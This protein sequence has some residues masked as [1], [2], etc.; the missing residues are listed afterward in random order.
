MRQGAGVVG[1]IEKHRQDI[2]SIHEALVL[3]LRDYAAKCRFKSVVLGLSGGIDSAVVCTLAVAALGADCV[4]GV[5]MP[6]RYSS[7]HSVADAKELAHN[8]GIHFHVI[9][10]ESA[11]IAFENMLSGVFAGLR[12]DLA[13]ENIQAR[14]RGTTLMALSNKFNHLLLT[15]GNKSEVATGYCTL[16]GDMAG[17]LAVISDVPKMV[18]YQLAE[19]I[20]QRAGR[21]LIP[22]STISKPPSAE[23]RP[24]QK[25]A[26]SLPPY[27]VLDAIIY[28]Y[29]EEEIGATQIIAEGFDPAT[30]MA[31]IRLMDRSEYKRRQAAPGLKVTSRAFGFGR[32]MPIAQ[33]YRQPVPTVGQ[34]AEAF[35]DSAAPQPR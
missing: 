1:R 16:Y 25:D 3:G 20:N 12:P 26:D 24:N 6:S 19:Y 33:N 7:E 28:R 29:I 23:L 5:A 9:P 11:H 2:A 27:E 10:I 8:L 18:V 34:V 31:V 14:I 21:D 15:T 30:V 13:E 17:G 35:S 22:R 32:R 4:T